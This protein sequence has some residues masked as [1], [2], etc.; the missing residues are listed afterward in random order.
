MLFKLLNVK[1]QQ[2]KPLVMPKVM[3]NAIER[4]SML[5]AH[6]VEH[7]QITENSLILLLILLNKPYKAVRM[8]VQ[9]MELSA[10]NLNGIVS[11]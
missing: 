6:A 1:Y 9:D 4:N 10:K 7:M 5:Q 11:T 8:H 2:L 3:E